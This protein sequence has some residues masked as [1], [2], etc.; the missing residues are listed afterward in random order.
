MG[1]D[2]VSD[3]SRLAQRALLQP[4]DAGIDSSLDRELC[5]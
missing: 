1:D 3:E 4:R 2:K 5:M